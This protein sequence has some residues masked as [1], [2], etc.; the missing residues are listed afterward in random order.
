MPDG[1]NAAFRVWESSIQEPGLEAQF[2]EIRTFNGQGIDDPYA[3][4]RMDFNPYFGFHA[5]ILSI[6]GNVYID[7][8]SRGNIVDYVSYFGNEYFRDFPFDCR[9]ENSETAAKPGEVQAVACRGQFLKTFRLA[10]ACTGEYAQAV[11]GS[12]NASTLHAAIVTTV[13]RVVGVYEKEISVRLVLVANNNLIEYQ[14]P[15]TDPFTGNSNTNAGQL[16]DLSQTV[17]TNRIGTNNFDIGHTFSTGAGGLAVLGC[18]CDNSIKARGVTGSPSPIGDKYDIDFVAHEMGHQLGASHTFNSQT[19]GCGGNRN[20]SSAYEVGSG[21]TIMGYANLCSTD[22]IQSQSDAFFHAIS[23]DEI[24]AR[25][26]NTCGTN[27]STGNSLPSITAMLNNGVSIPIN[28]PFT[29]SGTAIDQDN[30][31]LTY[32]WEEW[33]LGPSTEWNKGNNN[34]TSPLF[35]SRIPKTTGS[36]TF[37][38][39]KVI[40]NNYPASPAAEVGGLKGE[41]LPTK[42]RTMKFKLTV[43]D[44][45]AGGSGI[46]SGGAGCQT[47]FTSDFKINITGTSAFQVTYPNGGETIPGGSQIDVKWNVANTN[48]APIN[49]STV[50][51]M[52]SIDSGFTYPYQLV[53]STDNDGIESVTLPAIQSTKARVKVE[54]IGNIYFDISNR[55]FT[56]SAPIAGFTFLPAAQGNIVCGSGSNGSI[57]LAT[58]VTGGLSTPIS[59]T[60]S[61][62]PA[63]TTVSFSK[64]PLIP[65]DSTIVRLNNT[66]NLTPGIYSVKISG[67]AG[68][69]NQTTSVDFV[70]IPGQGPSFSSQPTSA[71]VCEE[72]NVLFNTVVSG[73]DSLQWQVSTDNGLNWA[74]LSEGGSYTGTRTAALQISMT[75][76]SQ[77]NYQFRLLAFGRCGNSFSNSALLTVLPLPSIAST[78]KNQNICTGSNLSLSVLATGANLNYQWE[79]STDGCNSFADMPGQTFSSLNISGA[80]SLLND[81]CFRVRINGQCLTQPILSNS[82]IIKV[83][84][85][86]SIG[87]APQSISLCEG[88]DAQF[89]AAINGGI[90]GLQWQVLTPG[91]SSW[92]NIFGEN[93]DVLEISNL[94]TSFNNNFYRLLVAGCNANFITDSAKLMVFDSVEIIRQPVTKDICLSTGNNIINFNA[95]AEG[96]VSS[97][98]WQV[99]KPGSSSWIDLQDD[100]TYSGSLGDSLNINNP[101]TGFTGNLYR[102]QITGFCN[103]SGLY[104]DSSI[105]LTVKLPVKILREPSDSAVCLNRDS[106]AQFEVL[107]EGTGIAY[108][109]QQRPSPQNAWTNIANANASSLLLDNLTTISDGYEYRV[110]INGACSNN[111]I[112]RVAKLSVYGD[113]FLTNLR[114]TLVCLPGPVNFIANT[115]NSAVAYQ[116][117][118]STNNGTSWDSI[119]GATS[120]QYV[121]GPLNSGDNGKL[122]RV[123]VNTSTCDGIFISKPAKISTGL[124][125]EVSVQGGDNF[126]I[127]PSSRIK[128]NSEVSFPAS[129]SYKWFR[130]NGGQP[131]STAKDIEINASATGRYFVT[132]FNPASNCLDSSET[133]V[134]DATASEQLFIFPNPNNGKFTISYYYSGG[135][136]SEIRTLNIYDSKGSRVLS[137]SV[138]ISQPYTY[139]EVN[140][141]QAAAGTYMAE[142]LDKT[143][144]RVASGKVVVQ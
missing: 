81:N 85:N 100:A 105:S 130:N 59:L 143:K 44:N 16:I 20:Q 49:T 137:R 25:I 72:S 141:P 106:S 113:P 77:D 66:A 144:K 51:I 23:Y 138:S 22:D 93:G 92:T 68:N 36:R 34:T 39:M 62:N 71:S 116:W 142:L 78:L 19:G 3:T 69:I 73:A 97:Y 82:A 33:D 24:S 134:I 109:W 102:L 70:V 10:V 14:N 89:A 43:R 4:I 48:L 87:S 107:G 58:S 5:Q 67:D 126:S 8:Y 28:T 99:L 131:V 123:I 54:A 75:A 83:F 60:A 52:L 40:V 31:A 96:N 18:I 37:P 88:S 103:P 129:Y 11:G 57:T 118:A 128:L 90:S 26:S 115:D 30:D 127:T 104:T 45:R 50:R 13:N 110:L 119:S 76:P 29:L 135:T 86:T 79:K 53:A 1:R 35:K 32:C 63:S 15:N 120:K 124:K 46:V 101:D 133:V 111:V 139:L 125:H 95:K 114:D 56:L 121:S 6:L 108:Q 74:S 17:I 136:T 122:F 12:S 84:D 91:A 21:T 140:L 80:N 38:D 42:S 132:A 47:G 27:T 55:N 41:T 65:G 61:N 64:N 94:N 9:F 117:E 112:S 98:Q 7:P 2:P